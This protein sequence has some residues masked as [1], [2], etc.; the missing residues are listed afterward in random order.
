[1]ATARIHSLQESLLRVT[2]ETPRNGR[3]QWMW[4]ARGAQAP[5][6]GAGAA[7]RS[8]PVVLLQALAGVRR[9]PPFPAPAVNFPTFTILICGALE[10]S[11]PVVQ[12]PVIHRLGTA[13]P[14]LQQRGVT[15]TEQ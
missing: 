5:K 12:S 10:T 7:G 8:L 3:D 13:T 11:S 9:T 2:G 4:Q 14:R 6:C 15:P 1:M